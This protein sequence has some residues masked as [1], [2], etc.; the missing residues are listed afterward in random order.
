MLLTKLHCAL[1]NC[2]NV[3]NIVGVI[4][5]CF[6]YQLLSGNKNMTTTICRQLVPSPA[7][8]TRLL[9][10][11]IDMSQAWLVPV[12]TVV[13]FPTSCSN[14]D[15]GAPIP[16]GHVV[17]RM[18]RLLWPMVLVVVLLLLM[19]QCVLGAA[20]V[21]A[22]RTMVVRWVLLG[23]GMLLVL[24]AGVEPVFVLKVSARGVRKQVGEVIVRVVIVGG[25][26]VL[27]LLV[28]ARHHPVRRVWAMGGEGVRNLLGEQKVREF[29]G[30][31]ASHR[32]QIIRALG[33]L[34][35]RN[36]FERIGGGEVVVGWGIRGT[37]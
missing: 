19:V 20:G 28:C 27:V 31:A 13:S 10:A 34:A 6:G 36:Q 7:L 3:L 2:L 32:S 1:T 12:I 21:V 15:T 5:L 8:S 37:D 18:G 22:T 33:V 24:V 25:A 4:R 26:V 17:L 29:I 35:P 11:L 14:I 9:L 30:V 16:R 23:L